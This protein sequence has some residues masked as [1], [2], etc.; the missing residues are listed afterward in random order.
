MAAE[1][2]M[3]SIK[4]ARLRRDAHD[5]CRKTA[6]GFPSHVEAQGLVVGKRRLYAAAG[7]LKFPVRGLASHYRSDDDSE[8]G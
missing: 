6:G 8:R 5:T 1:D 2:E 4:V 7:S 3:E